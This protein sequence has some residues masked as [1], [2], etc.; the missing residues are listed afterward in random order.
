MTAADPI[1]ASALPVLAP[2]SNAAPVMPDAWSATVVLHPFGPPPGT[3]PVPDTPF[4]A[5]R[6]AAI[7]F[8]AGRFLSVRI[9]GH[10]HGW[11]YIVTPGGTRLSVDHGV[12]WADIDCGWTLPTDWYGAQRATAACAGSSPLH[13]VAPRPVDWW[14]LQVPLGTGSPPGATWLWFDSATHDPVRM[15]FGVSPPAPAMGDPTQLGFFQNFSLICFADFTRY[16]PG[17]APALPTSWVEPSLAHFRFGNPHHFKPFE[18]NHNFGLTSFSTPVNGLFNPLQTRTL[19]AWKSDADYR[20]YTDRAQSTLMHYRYNPH[21]PAGG[22]AIDAVES[23]LTGIAPAGKTAAHSGTGY[24]YTR[25]RDGTEGCVTGAKFQFGA[26]APKWVSIKGVH[27]T[28][29]ATIDAHPR[30]CPDVVVTIY[31]VLFP[32]NDKYPDGVYLWTWY[33]PDPGS[34][35]SASRPVLFMQADSG[36]NEG[37]SLALAD[38]FFYRNLEAPI[39]PANFVVPG[40]CLKLA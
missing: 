20:V 12:H 21:Q 33:A 26:E 27:G 4:Y 36:V 29:A 16:A 38:Y 9:G 24:L 22:K 6:I 15:M 39:D 19:Y 28:L 30:L 35:G 37:T 18:W 11:W 14:R 32:P 5:L 31:S 40:A 7:D 25:Y 2:V 23:L 8:S 17:H 3:G 13:W 34:D 10:A 1:P